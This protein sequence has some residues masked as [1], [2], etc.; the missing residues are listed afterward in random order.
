LADA[1]PGGI[2]VPPATKSRPP[3]S[4]DMHASL[5]SF[6]RRRDAFAT[7]VQRHLPRGAKV[8]DVASGTHDIPLRLLALDPTLH[9]EAVDAS[10]HM[11]AEGQR[12]AHERNLTITARVCDAHELPFDDGSFDAVTLRFASRH[13][14]FPSRTS[15]IAGTSA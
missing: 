13:L 15:P 2:A 3:K 10:E 14:E 11:I 9:V 8:L 7:A 6:G 4:S 12:R 1:T 5:G